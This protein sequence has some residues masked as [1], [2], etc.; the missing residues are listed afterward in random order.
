MKGLTEFV[1]RVHDL[2][3]SQQ[4]L[5]FHE[6]NEIQLADPLLSV[7]VDVKSEFPYNGKSVI[8]VLRPVV[9]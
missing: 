5:R 3:K 8:V 4:G 2:L 7:V 1:C 9:D 6:A